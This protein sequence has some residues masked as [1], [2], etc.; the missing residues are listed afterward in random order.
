MEDGNAQAGIQHIKEKT[1]IAGSPISDEQR[2]NCEAGHELAADGHRKRGRS[3][4]KLESNSERR[5]ANYGNGLGK[6]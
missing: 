2:Q 1:K 3:R 6:R 4:K 5:F